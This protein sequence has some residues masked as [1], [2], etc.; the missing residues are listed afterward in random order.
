MLETPKNIEQVIEP[1]EPVEMEQL[2][3]G[4]GIISSRKI[5]PCDK[6]RPNHP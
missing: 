6:L 4:F 3:L 2:K 5:H 1:G